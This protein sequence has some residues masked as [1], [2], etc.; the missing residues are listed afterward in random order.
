MQSE[1]LSS[2]PH[3]TQMTLETLNLDF[4]KTDGLIPAI[5]QDHATLQVLMLGFMDR[6]ALE[7]TLSSGRVTFFSRSRQSLWTKGETSG[8]WLRLVSIETDCDRD[9]LLVKVRPD[10]PVCHNGTT[11]CFNP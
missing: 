1:P 6:A 11:S 5:V 2:N 3:A 7:E 10:G 4:D 8:N 9:S